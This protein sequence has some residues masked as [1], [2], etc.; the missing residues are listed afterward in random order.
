MYLYVKAPDH[1]VEASSDEN[2]AH[3]LQTAD[4]STMTLDHM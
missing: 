2:L 4:R 3:D 1:F